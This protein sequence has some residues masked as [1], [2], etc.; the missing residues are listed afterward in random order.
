M[1][2]GVLH[3]GSWYTLRAI[4]A[5]AS[6]AI[7]STCAFG[8][9]T[10]RY[11]SI[12]M[13]AGALSGA[14]LG[15]NEAGNVVGVSTMP[16]GVRVGWFYERATHTT[17]IMAA[18]G[19]SAAGREIG[20]HSL[21][22]SNQAVG[23]YGAAGIPHSFKWSPDEG[24]QDITYFPS[25]PMVNNTVVSHVYAINNAGHI[26]GVNS[27][28]CT[29]SPTFGVEAAVLWLSLDDPPMPLIGTPFSCGVGGIV[30]DLSQ[31]DAVCGDFTLLVGGFSWTRPTYIDGVG[32]HDLQ[33]FGG[34]S[35]HGN[36]NGLNDTGFVCGFAENR[37]GGTPFSGACYWDFVGNIHRLDGIPQASLAIA[38]DI[39]NGLDIVGTNIGSNNRRAL[40][41]QAPDSTAIDLNAVTA[42][43]PSGHIMTTAEEI[44][45][46]GFIVGRTNE[47]SG[48]RAFL[49]E[50]CRPVVV[51]PPEDMQVQSGETL[52]LEIEAAGAGELMYLWLHNQVVLSDGPGPGGSLISGA[53]GP[54]LTIE[55]AV[56]A[57]A[58]LYEVVITTEC[59]ELL[60][61]P[62][63]VEILT[64]PSD[65]D[66]SGYVDI[67][68]YT[69]FIAAFEAGDEDADYDGTGFVDTDDFTEFIHDFEQGC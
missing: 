3:T 32:R 67:D 44:S 31:F 26:A 27:W 52:T 24:F 7:T 62:I 60:T 23:T 20:P 21:N 6:S 16:G 58:G 55:G 53:S 9:A 56:P 41:W 63:T 17:H 34:V 50:P 61:P 49:L 66:L 2:R 38:Y 35:E 33:T 14:A 45:D 4:V 12:P 10:Y 18:L 13:P 29:S 69:A 22:D 59:G 11:V 8:Q 19:T 47:L 30:R 37:T 25:E 40:L 57:N 43:I 54:V 15:V 65:F 68:D 64:C 39:N 28:N 36:A 1:K 46:S 5:S 51:T 42:E 48:G